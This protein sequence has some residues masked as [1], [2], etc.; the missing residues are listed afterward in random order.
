[1][2]K[3]K[4]PLQN[5]YI[6]YSTNS[7]FAIPSNQEFVFFQSKQKDRL[8]FLLD[9]LN[10]TFEIDCETPDF[11]E[12]IDQHVHLAQTKGIGYLL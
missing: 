5:F 6:F 3:I 4:N 2:L 12:F 7:L 9:L 10:E 11:R 1:M 8:T